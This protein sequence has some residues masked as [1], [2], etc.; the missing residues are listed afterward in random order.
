[1]RA[2]RGRTARLAVLPAVARAVPW[3]LAAAAVLAFGARA[4]FGLTALGF[5][6]ETMHLL[7]GWALD[8]GDRLY[9]DFVDLHGPAI[10]MLAQAYGALF[11][12]AHANG[13]RVVIAALAVLAGGAVATSPALRGTARACAAMLFFG[14]LAT[15]WLVQSLYLFSYYPISGAFAVITLAWFVVPAC[16]RAELP[17]GLAFAAGVASALL[18]FTSYSEAPTA[19]LFSAG[20]ALAAWRGGQAAGARAHLAGALAA[21]LLLLAWLAVW[22]DVAGYL[23][24]HILFGITVYPQV[25]PLSWRGLLASLTPSWQANRLVQSAAVIFAVLGALAMTP[26]CLRAGPGRA[27]RI[28]CVAATLAGLVLLDL[29]ALTIFQNGALLVG[30]IGWFTLCVPAGLERLWPSSR[31]ASAWAGAACLATIVLTEA[32]MRHAVYSPSG[33]TRAVFLRQPPSHVAGP[34]PGAPF[35]TIDR[36]TRPDERI[37]SLVY[38]PGSYFAARRLPIKGLYEY[39]PTDAI[40]ARH[41]W[42]GQTRDLCTILRSSPPPVILFDDW[43]VWGIYKPIDYMPCLFEVLSRRYTYVPEP[44]DQAHGAQKLFV[45]TDRMK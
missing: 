12:W 13:A 11:G 20:G 10:F 44:G 16:T 23:A 3:V 21:G 40:Y 34:M 28:A 4:V 5:N 2:G 41:P 36:L 18:A 9:R 7:G 39:L 42:L 33:L 29:R 1:M 19:L 27:A 15:V 14:L 24:F 32:V 26:L 35:D 43:A 30:S 17:P 45:R 6:D 38:G 22:S 8:S 37:L 25:G 31:S